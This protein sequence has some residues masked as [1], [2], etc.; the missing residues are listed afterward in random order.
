MP[1]GVISR[2]LTRTYHRLS[3]CSNQQT[4]KDDQQ[5]ESAQITVLCNDIQLSSLFKKA[6][7]YG[8]FLTAV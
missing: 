2:N 5:K 6:K 7:F 1:N 4:W 3:T 8:S